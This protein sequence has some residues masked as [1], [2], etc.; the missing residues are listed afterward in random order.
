MDSRFFK[1]YPRL[2]TILNEKFMIKLH[3]SLPA[4]SKNKAPN[5]NSYA[6]F[7]DVTGIGSIRPYTGMDILNSEKLAYEQL[8]LFSGFVRTEYSYLPKHSQHHII[9]SHVTAISK[10]V[11]ANGI[12]LDTGNL[13]TFDNVEE[14]KYNFNH[15]NSYYF[16]LNIYHHFFAK[17]IVNG[18]LPHA[19]IKDWSRMMAQYTSCFIEGGLFEGPLY[20]FVIPKFKSRKRTIRHFQLVVHSP[21]RNKN[22]CMVVFPCTLKMKKS[23]LKYKHDWIMNLAT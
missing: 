19:A 15:G 11:G 12:T 6:A 22:N 20:Q 4:A 23:L 1:G 5:L 18:G 16:M 7:I 17:R 2:S 3:N 14:L 9:W 21:K 10:V 13:L 8:K